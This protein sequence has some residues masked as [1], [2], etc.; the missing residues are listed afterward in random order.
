MH[1][2]YYFRLHT[3][4]STK[5]I[6]LTGELAKFK[7]DSWAPTYEHTVL[8]LCI[9]LLRGWGELFEGDFADVCI[10][11]I[12]HQRELNLDMWYLLPNIKHNLV[13]ATKH[14]A[15]LLQPHTWLEQKLFEFIHF[16]PYCTYFYSSCPNFHN[17]I[18]YH[19]SIKMWRNAVHDTVMYETLYW[20]HP[21]VIRTIY[22]DPVGRGQRSKTR[23]Q[24]Q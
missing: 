3:F 19:N 17:S 18:A 23:C 1:S 9:W 12:P 21:A 10:K 22:T 8:K 7:Y 16:E 24:L 20:Y 6:N 2:Y 14:T 11:Q 4:Y 15:R 13:P 5:F